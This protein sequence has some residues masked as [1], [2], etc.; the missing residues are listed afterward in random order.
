MRT[1]LGIDESLINEAMKYT[2]LPTKKA[3]IEEALR[4]LVRLKSQQQIRELRGQLKWEGDLDAMREGRFQ[5][6]SEPNNLE[7]DH[8]DR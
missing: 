7:G 4:T 8:V 3:G 1:N 6:D 5:S 2:G